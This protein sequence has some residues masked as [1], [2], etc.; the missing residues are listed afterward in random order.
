MVILITI[1]LTA[2]LFIGVPLGFAFALAVLLGAPEFSLSL[3][4]LIAIPVD[5]VG[6]Y[7][8]TA[9]P[10]F[11]LVGVIMSHGGL[12]YRLTRFCDMLLNRVKASYGYIMIGAS[13]LFGAISG[14]SV[15]TVAA[16]GSVVSPEMKKRGYDS[17]YVAALN[18]ATGLL[19]VLLP[20]SIPLILYGSLVGVSIPRLFL[21]TIGPAV[22]FIAVLCIVHRLRSTRVL[23][24]GVEE[25]EADFVSAA[26][27]AA[28]FRKVFIE[29]APT[30]IL[31]VIILGGIYGGFFT[32]TESAAVGCVYAL[33][34]CFAYRTV[35]FNSLFT[36][37]Y[38]ALVPAAAV[39]V[40]IAFTGIL[41][42]VLVLNQVPQELAAYITGIIDTPVG[43]LIAVNI[44]GLLI[45]MLMETN[46]AVLLLGPLLAPAAAQYGIDPVHFG[47]L[48][49]ANIE[50]GLLTPPL[51]ANLFV[52]MKINDVPILGIMKEIIP[53]FLAALMCQIAVTFIPQIAL[54]YTLF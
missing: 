6:V 35:R 36:T 15:A 47:I 24:R 22:L 4:S 23:K 10:M 53:F 52:A 1:L 3:D 43:F 48:L 30:L 31:P 51:A 44:L 12:A 50:L 16:I 33:M 9:I 25:K 27:G 2:F 39:L 40:V 26:E 18:A 38:R 32:P 19:G 49:V 37:L 41:N 54:W 14:S 42:R 5:A 13:T 20:P 17:N 29:V 7:P 45:G 28:A 8:L 34:L 11:I 21:G 46:A